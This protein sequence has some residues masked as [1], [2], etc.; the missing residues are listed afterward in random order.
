MVYNLT[1]LFP[2]QSGL[3]SP[4]EA[5]GHVPSFIS[6]SRR[7]AAPAGSYTD[8]IRF[9]TDSNCK[10]YRHLDGL[11]IADWAKYTVVH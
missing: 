7:Q 5:K 3:T 9:E 6:M 4:T 8:S 1:S 11:T 2:I 10:F